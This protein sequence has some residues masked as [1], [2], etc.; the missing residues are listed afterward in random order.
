MGNIL[1]G[2]SMGSN[3]ENYVKVSLEDWMFLFPVMRSY[4]VN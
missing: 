1:P 3:Y 4:N 2:R